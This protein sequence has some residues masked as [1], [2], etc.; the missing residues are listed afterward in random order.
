MRCD[1]SSF[2]TGIVVEEAHDD[3]RRCLSKTLSL[4]TY[5]TFSKA[6]QLRYQ[7]G[8]ALTS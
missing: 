3:P 1:E 8:V 5:S 4:H 7:S 6:D 2:R